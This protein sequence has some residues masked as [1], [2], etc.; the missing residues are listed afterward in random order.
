MNKT[1]QA[2]M[3]A[4][5]KLLPVAKKISDFITD[6]P[7]VSGTEILSSQ[8]YCRTL[9]EYGFEVIQN[10]CG[11]QHAFLAK[12]KKI[13]SKRAVLM[14]EYDALPGIGH[15]CGH[16]L[17]G[18]ASLLA[19]LALEENQ[20]ES[21]F[22]VDLMGTPGE[23]A[24]GGKIQLLDQGAFSDYEFAAMVHMDSINSI[25]FKTLACNDRYFTFT[26]RSAHASGEPEKGI[27]ALNAA[28]L[29]MDAMDMWR[30]HLPK[31]SQFHGIVE[32]GGG[33][34]N[35]VPDKAILDYYFRAED[36]AD[37]KKL[38]KVAENC[39]TA[40]AMAMNAQ[41]EVEQRYPTYADIYVPA[42]TQEVLGVIFKNLNLP[43]DPFGGSLGSTDAGN[44]DQLIPVFHPTVAITEGVRFPLHHKDFEQLMKQ[45]SGYEGLKYSA[46]LLVL[47]INRL[48]D[49]KGNFEQIKIQHRA[50]RQKIHETD[51]A[52]GL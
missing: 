24:D 7:E 26:G 17:S 5:E 11:V 35:V 29:Y 52:K 42:A 12:S 15:A 36:M 39:A 14:A 1:E 45:P 31:G 9:E 47:L 44:I 38:N 28:R 22:S 41:V 13:M 20:D 3:A 34:P 10:Y 21:L 2:G 4:V 51:F 40:A 48:S 25:C 46:Q 43:L 50:Y 18:A 33:S 8:E 19:F 16:S 32:N 6:H 37:L 27:N 23:E 49:P 30:Q